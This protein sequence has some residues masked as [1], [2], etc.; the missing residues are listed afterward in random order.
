MKLDYVGDDS[1]DSEDGAGS[2][3]GSRD[4]SRE[5]QNEPDC[6]MVTIRVW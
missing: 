6:V 3:F 1:D 2:E 5:V 4:R